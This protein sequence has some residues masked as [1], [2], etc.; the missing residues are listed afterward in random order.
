MKTKSKQESR[1]VKGVMTK[2]TKAYFDEIKIQRLPSTALSN[3]RD[4]R[5]AND[6]KES[7]VSLAKTIIAILNSKKYDID[8]K[9][10]LITELCYQHKFLVE[11]E[12]RNKVSGI[13]LEFKKK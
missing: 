12:T 13:L 7:R 8:K 1:V 11:Y 10:E 4:S 5:K 6:L 3:L 9:A 2:G